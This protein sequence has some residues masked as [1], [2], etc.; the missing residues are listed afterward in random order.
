MIARYLGTAALAAAFSTPQ[1]LSAQATP[2][3]PAPSYELKGTIVDGSNRPLGLVEV[4]LIRDAAVVHT[5]LSG[6]NGRFTFGRVAAGQVMLHFR[7]IGYAAQTIDMVVGPGG[8]PSVSEIVLVELPS[9]LTDV[10]INTAAEDERYRSFYERKR[11]RA[12]FGRFLEHK[13]IRRLGPANPSDLFR[14]VPGT[15]IRS[16][17][18]YGNTIRV[19]G[20]QPMVWVDGQ[21]VPGAELDEVVQPTEIGAIEFYPSSA[22]VPA[23]YMER[24]NRL[25]GLILVWTR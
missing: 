4:V 20:C 11:Q 2:A 22:G 18:L 12:S 17:N 1:S 6:D 15:T 19:R 16:A 23:Q 10:T 8:H 5:V 7:R 13:D 3:A 24:G 14:T 21:R 9:Q 25:C